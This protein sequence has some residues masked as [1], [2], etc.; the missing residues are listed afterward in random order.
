MSYAVEQAITGKP[1]GL[2]L[3]G[4]CKGNQRKLKTDPERLTQE[5]QDTG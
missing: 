1:L 3:P 2:K 5:R 4:R